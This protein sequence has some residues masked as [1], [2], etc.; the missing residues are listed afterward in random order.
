[1]LLTEDISVHFGGVRAIG[2]AG[3]EA[4]AGQVTGLIGPNGAGKTTMFN[5]ITGL[6]KPNS[7]RVLLDGTDITRMRPRDRA[8]KGIGRTFQRLEVFGS[9]S[10]RD[11]VMVALEA[12]RGTVS[13]RDRAESADQLLTRV[14]L[15]A[16]ANTMAEVL[17]TGMA[18]LLELA[19]ALA[20]QPK[21]LLLDEASSGLDN[22]ESNDLGELMVELAA[23]GIAVLLVEHDMDLVMR[24]C[25]QIHVLDFGQMIASGTPEE[26]QRNPK[27]QAAYL[28]TDDIGTAEEIH[29]AQEVDL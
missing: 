7:G 5:V 18:R 3:F 17:P 16:S 10:V 9:L 15:T 12:R 11:N 2:G 22:R 13:R 23:E 19:R 27:V 26:I 14:G 4:R 25:E 24:V 8:R 28:G 6:Q 20:A 1:V 21:V 29:L